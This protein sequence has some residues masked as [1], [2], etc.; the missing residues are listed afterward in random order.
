M[1]DPTSA[2]GS[3]LPAG[4]EHRRPVGVSDATVQAAGKVTEALEWVERVRGH[5]YE[6][7]QM[8]GHADLLFGEAADMLAEAGHDDLA[9][10]MRREIVGRN[11]FPGRWTF[12]LVEE[13]DDGY[14][15]AVKDFERR[16][17]DELLDGRR[18]VMESEMKE[19]RRTH[20][21]PGHEAR[22]S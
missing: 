6:A 17:R 20:G 7:H 10:D 3:D 13:F 21:R 15:S 12:Q 2:K 5:L 18:H 16:T 11:T 1:S 9:A 4:D 14:Y 19:S 8:S 22:P